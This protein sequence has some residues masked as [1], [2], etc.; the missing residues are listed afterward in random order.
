M[1]KAAHKEKL[2]RIR[3]EKKLRDK[4]KHL[5]LWGIETPLEWADF[6]KKEEMAGT[7][8]EAV[9]K[10]SQPVKLDLSRKKPPLTT[11]ARPVLSAASVT[12]TKT[13][14]VGSSSASMPMSSSFRLFPLNPILECSKD[15]VVRKVGTT[16]PYGSYIDEHGGQHWI[17]TQ[18]RKVKR[19][20]IIAATWH[21]DGRNLK[22]GHLGVGTIGL[23]HVW[24]K[25]GKYSNC[26]I[27]NLVIATMEE[28]KGMTSTYPCLMGP[29]KK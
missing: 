21:A 2:A 4:C 9:V 15:G 3:E 23:Y 24:H 11:V 6:P 22:L 27:E 26:N 20:H 18:Q 8:E 16:V 12:R 7:T 13:A 5:P 29:W 28:A 10:H 17:R 19:S 14:A 1:G 25:D